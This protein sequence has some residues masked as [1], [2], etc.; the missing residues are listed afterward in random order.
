MLTP[1]LL[2]WS[3]IALYSW[4]YLSCW[5]FPEHS[6]IPIFLPKTNEHFWPNALAHYKCIPRTCVHVERLNGESSALDPTTVWT[7]V[8]V[9]HEHGDSVHRLQRCWRDRSA[10]RAL[11]LPQGDRCRLTRAP[12]LKTAGHIWRALPVG[13]T[14]DECACAWLSCLHRLQLYVLFLLCIYSYSAL[15]H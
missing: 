4:F 9:L 12:T 3:K 1:L 15:A 7:Q 6:L 5:I 2:V 13:Q 10:D 14:T 8:L 11:A